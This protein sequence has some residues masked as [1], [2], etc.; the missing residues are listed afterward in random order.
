MKCGQSAAIKCT[1]TCG[2]QLNCGKHS[3]KAVCHSGSC[4]KCEE[5]VQQECYG[6][7]EK[8]EVDCGSSEDFAQSYSCDNIC[9]RYT[10]CIHSSGIYGV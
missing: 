2:R 5:K 3:C 10:F 4:D 8:R 9:A 1:S 7:H 6:S